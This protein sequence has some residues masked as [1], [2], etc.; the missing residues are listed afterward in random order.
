M[1]S[2]TRYI[3]VGLMLLAISGCRDEFTV[4]EATGEGEARVSATL[5]FKPM[6][7]ALT[8]S[9]AAGNALKDIASLHVLLYN[10]DKSLIKSW[11]ISQYDISEKIRVDEDAENR[12]SAETTTKRAIL[13]L[14][15]KIEF[16]KYYMYAVANIPD[17]LDN[18]AYADSILS[19]GGL[20]NIPLVW[21]SENIANNGQML[22][23][24]TTTSAPQSEDAPLVI[25]EKNVSLHAWL[26]RAASK[27]TV[28][29]D[30]SGLK[31]GIS[32]FL[33]A[34][35]IK[36]IPKK[37]SLGSDNTVTDTMH[38]Q[39]GE[40]VVYC[41]S[42]NYDKDYPAL[43][44]K[45]L[46]YY[47][48]IQ[49][50]EEDGT[51]S[52]LMDPDRHSE[53]NPNSLFFYEN[54]Q[55]SGPDLPDKRPHDEDN[56]GILDILYQYKK[57]N[58]ATYIE[59]DAFYE[60]TDSLRP[61]MCNITYRFMLGQDIIQDYNAKRNCHYKLTLHFNGYADDP[62]WRIDYVTRLWAT[63]PDTVDYRGMY[64]VPTANISNHGNKFS[65]D[66]IIT[67][68]SF[69][70]DNDSWTE[71]KAQPYK[72][73]YRDAGCTEF[74][75]TCPAWLNAFSK[76]D[77][78]NGIH[79]L[80]INYANPYISVP[81]NDTIRQ[82]PAKSGIYDLSTKGGSTSMNTANCYI[83]DSKGTYQF[84]L[85]YGNA[86]VDGDANEASYKYQGGGNTS[87]YLKTFLNYKNQAIKSPYILK[88]IYGTSVPANLTPSIVWQDEKDL[89][90]NIAYIPGD[91]GYIKFEVNNPKEGNAVIA[92][93]DPDNTIMW[94]WHIW[95][96]AMDLTKT[97]TLTNAKAYGGSRQ[98]EIMP[99]NLGWCSGGTPVRY[100]ERH[101]CEVK[102]TQLINKGGDS[103]EEGLSRIVRIVQEP[104]IALP[105]G[106]NPYYQHGRKDPFVA[107]GG[108]NN[109]NKQWYDASGLS[110]T[111]AP[112]TITDPAPEN[113]PKRI[114]TN[115]ATALLIRNPDK[116]QNCPH[117]EN[118]DTAIAGD[119]V[120]EDNI[121]FNLWDNSCWDDNDDVVKTVYDPCPVGYHVS[122]IY[123]FSG[124]TDF[125]GSVSGL[126]ST[127]TY[128]VIE[129]NM[130]DDPAYRD[131]I[132]EF[133]TNKTK[134]ISIGF[135]ANGYRDWDDN[136]KVWQYGQGEVWCAQGA[137]WSAISLNGV[138]YYPNA[139]HLE[140]TR[141]TNG[142]VP[143]I[144]P[145][146]NY[147]A[148]DGMAVRPSKTLP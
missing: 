87:N 103:E 42:K 117:K 46:P 33:K 6:A 123:T 81:I 139:Y 69:M 68:T 39:S 16:G 126:Y 49:K 14:P 25:N 1:K 118:N 131:N 130:L 15:E 96:T 125:G 4:M 101:E 30:G 24:C 5:D 19:V 31:E 40:E 32:I 77:K 120:P 50:T 143:H 54:M 59:V 127:N 132:V 48:R 93:K 124:F 62:D 57:M 104:H 99:V 71:R 78:G 45:D 28:A 72:I 105:C 109:T 92:L 84:P 134:L 34:V 17:L 89:V 82:R 111:S 73:E 74:S 36:K 2:F 76:T 145:W 86:I 9:R 100:Y 94:S 51:M 58:C 142:F 112:Q 128:A 63:Q 21:D 80:K 20:K 61:G 136:A 66:N 56:N 75:D 10:E 138:A 23:Y 35:R 140:F 121:F 108:A 8:R 122:S 137:L 12:K 147:Y 113:D 107:S 95:V 7:E 83:V 79:E 64:F 44:T 133:Y 115:E 106:N 38:L 11:K 141:L 90:T 29:F 43:I 18:S 148:T 70:Y 114:K 97:L 146:N 116:W 85:V 27:V 37:C 22:G 53:T 102:F 110:S 47:P 3:I 135:L 26:R 91:P 119:Y 60:S 88:D 129:E 52:W 41:E 67:V 65:A 13:E 55:G 144:F 98:Y